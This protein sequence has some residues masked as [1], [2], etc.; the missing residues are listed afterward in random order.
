MKDIQ[1]TFKDLGIEDIFNRERAGASII[2]DKIRCDYYDYL[3]GTP[4]GI[5]AFKGEYMM[6]YSWAETT[7]AALYDEF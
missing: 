6:Q 7:G 2:V 5:N 4:E 1:D 3:K